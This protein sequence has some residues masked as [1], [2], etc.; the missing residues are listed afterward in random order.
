MKKVSLFL[1]LLAIVCI[2]FTSC[3]KDPDLGSVGDYFAFGHFYGFCAGEQC[4]EIFKLENK[5]LLEDQMDTYPS[6]Q[7]KGSRNYASMSFT[8]EELAMANQLMADLPAELFAESDVVFGCP[9]CAD[10]G[11]T[12]IEIKRDGVQHH[13]ILDNAK[14]NIPAYLRSYS[15]Q[16]RLLSNQLSE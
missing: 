9:D 8:A 5:Q 2:S 13:W 12:Y 4:I 1:S 7:D 14:N 11:G 6:E 15:D 3:K 16:I 10:Q